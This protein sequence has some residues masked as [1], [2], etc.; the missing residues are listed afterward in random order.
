M[1]IEVTPHEAAVPGQG[2]EG[3]ATT[4]VTVATAGRQALLREEAAAGAALR[5]LFWLQGHQRLELVAA[6][7]MPDHLHAVVTPAHGRLADAMH[8]FRAVSAPEIK[9]ILAW[10]GPV[11]EPR[12]R[13]RAIHDSAG[14]RWWIERCYAD[15]TRDTGDKSRRRVPFWWCAREW[16]VG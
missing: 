8:V 16:S 10:E 4:L 12:C 5:T 14:L 6:A 1:S 7:V 2:L 15:L 11:W 9:R 13:R 3:G